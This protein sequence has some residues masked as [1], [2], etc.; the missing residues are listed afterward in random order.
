MAQSYEKMYEEAD[1]L[2][3]SPELLDRCEM[4]FIKAFRSLLYRLK[5][6]GEFDKA[7]HMLRS[8]I[9]A[10][11][12][13]YGEE[14]LEYTRSVYELVCTHLIQGRYDECECL[15][16]PLLEI[17]ERTLG[18]EHQYTLNTLCLLAECWKG[19]NRFKE[20][21]AMYKKIIRISERQSSSSKHVCMPIA[22]LGRV[23]HMQ[24]MLDLARE[25]YMTAIIGLKD[26][27]E[28]GDLDLLAYLTDLKDLTEVAGDDDQVNTLWQQIL[29][30][31][32]CW[33]GWGSNHPETISTLMEY[34][35]FLHCRSR[36]KELQVLWERVFVGREHNL[37]PVHGLTL[38]SQNLLASAL[39]ETKEWDRAIALGV[40]AVHK[41]GKVLETAP[42][43]DYKSKLRDLLVLKCDL[44]LYYQSCDKNPNLE[45]AEQ[46]L[47]EAL[48]GSEDFD[49]EDYRSFHNQ[50]IIRCQSRIGCLRRYQ[51]RLEES[52]EQLTQTLRH[53][54]ENLS[55]TDP[56]TFNCV[57]SLIR[58]LLPMN[59]YDE[60]I[61]LANEAIG[62]IEIKQRSLGRQGAILMKLKALGLKLQRRYAEAKPVVETALGLFTKQAGP[63]NYDTLQCTVILAI[64]EEQM[65][66]LT[67]AE[68]LYKRALAG[69]EETQGR[70]GED[71]AYLMI[72]VLEILHEQG[73]FDEIERLR[74]VW[75][76]EGATFTLIPGEDE[77]RAAE[78]DAHVDEANEELGVENKVGSP[79]AMP[80]VGHGDIEARLRPKRSVSRFRLAKL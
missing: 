64:C 53:C 38:S 80:V 50:I 76:A 70:F 39:C 36:F 32:L 40:D 8:M 52:R 46:H 57:T 33:G 79:Q 23:Y 11:L 15:A 58:T 60:A 73:K 42:S 19:Q 24:G 56:L 63:N 31:R 71:T 7:E 28:P 51:D 77:Q 69:Y 21:E 25:H 72:D 49:H 43:S 41:A 68:D 17:R 62:G 16:M 54:K 65:S 26:F 35:Q 61:N 10:Q 13:V 30:G 4:D 37:G 55:P 47:T 12:K 44:G 18:P 22:N 59:R 14:D 6:N 66:N 27:V 3:P 67:R 75:A 29:E 2:D 34:S 78:I 5:Q 74:T 9:P 20:A 45:A 48:L 1:L